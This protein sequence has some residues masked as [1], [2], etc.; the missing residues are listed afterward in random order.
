MITVVVEDKAAIQV[1][2][3]RNAQAAAEIL[4][5]LIVGYFTKIDLTTP[6]AIEQRLMIECDR[7]TVVIDYSIPNRLSVV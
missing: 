6:A 5:I 2:D 3:T 4:E 1:R 7:V